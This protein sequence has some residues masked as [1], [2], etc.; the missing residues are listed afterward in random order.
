MKKHN[1]RKGCLIISLVI[2]LAPII[3]LGICIYSISDE[4]FDSRDYI[5]DDTQL[6]YIKGKIER[7]LDVQIQDCELIFGRF[8]DVGPDYI[9]FAV[10]KIKDE[11]FLQQIV[12]NEE[13]FKATIIDEA[14]NDTT[15]YTPYGPYGEDMVAH[16][17]KPI[18][19]SD[20]RYEYIKP[21]DEASNCIIQ[22]TYDIDNKTLY[23]K[24]SDF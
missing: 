13:W 9:I 19:M 8:Y 23:Y 22:A 4:P 6:E 24:Y 11:N 16:T 15:D 2:I 7:D 20:N 14:D 10:L 1:K 17:G 5:F 18:N 12:T 3:F 21:Y